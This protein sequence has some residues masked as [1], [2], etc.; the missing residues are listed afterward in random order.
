MKK[1][2]LVVEDNLTAAG[3]MQIQL[4]LLGYE[5][6]VVTDG[7]E[8]VEV[9][10]SARPDLIVLDMRMPK[11]DGFDT[12]KQLRQNTGTKDIPILA[13]TAFANP[14]ARE[15]CLASG[16]DGYISKPFDHHQLGNAIAKLLN[17]ASPQKS[18][19]RQ[20]ETQTNGTQEHRE[21]G[22]EENAISKQGYKEALG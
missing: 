16:C 1:R 4:E 5:V 21:S 18:D 20:R 6:K 22:Q 9:A 15:K 19:K 8:A 14:G 7:L 11:L 12:A 13:A 2:I 17:H 10:P 3:M